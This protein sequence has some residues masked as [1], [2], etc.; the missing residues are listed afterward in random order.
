LLPPILRPNGMNPLSTLHRILSEGLHQETDERCI[1]LAMTIREV[2]VFL[3][4][5]VTATKASSSRFTESMR[6]LL[7]RRRGAAY[8]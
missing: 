6:K 7:D 2:L 5:Q 8:R 3:V 1:E 4:N